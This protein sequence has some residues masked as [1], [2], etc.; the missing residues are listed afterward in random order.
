VAELEE[1]LDV[2]GKFLIH[3]LR[4]SILDEMEASISGQSMRLNSYEMAQK[5][6]NFS[7]EDLDV[8]RELFTKSI[9]S[10]LSNF[11]W[12]MNEMSSSQ[13]SSRIKILVDGEDITGIEPFLQGELF[14]DEGWI[15][16]FS[17]YPSPQYHG[18][19]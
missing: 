3:G 19:Q 2:F 16:R 11:L 18:N 12:E 13:E 9:D 4:D 15:E 5:L 1:D 10:A 6:K 14:S 8:V 7:N 17:K